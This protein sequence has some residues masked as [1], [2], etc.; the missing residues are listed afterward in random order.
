MLI[1]SSV[2]Y[3]RWTATTA[4]YMEKCG[5]DT[6]KQ[7]EYAVLGA[8][9]EVGEIAGLL[10][11]EIRD[12]NPRDDRKLLLE[13]GDLAWYLARL[14]YDHQDIEVS[15][16]SS[17]YPIVVELDIL[18]EAKKVS[19]FDVAV[20]VSEMLKEHTGSKAAMANYIFGSKPE[21]LLD[22]LQQISDGLTKKEAI[23]HFMMGMNRR[24]EELEP[25][26]VLVHLV[27]N[28]TK[29]EAVFDWCSLCYKFG[30][31]IIDVL[32]ANVSKLE[33]RKEVGTL[34]GKGSAR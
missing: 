26:I 15:E 33:I 27:A 23:G 10:K 30:F 31:D 22:A 3:V 18:E 28:V 8:L 13:L 34:H 32:Q 1:T 4:L 9:D 12:D 19:C 29:M 5:D 11:R 16:D 20:M 21:T 25:A 2:D 14:H 6:N 17:I 7:V 24:I